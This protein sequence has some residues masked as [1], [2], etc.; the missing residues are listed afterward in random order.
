MFIGSGE[1]V[2]AKACSPG[3]WIGENGECEGGNGGAVNALSDFQQY[4]FATV[5]SLA[6]L[7]FG[8]GAMLI[9]YAGF[10]YTT[11]GFNDRAVEEAKKLMFRAAITIFISLMVFVILNVIATALGISM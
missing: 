4:A 5:Q 8:I 10:K 3:E 1:T 11:S 7:S 2:E 6:G 9:I